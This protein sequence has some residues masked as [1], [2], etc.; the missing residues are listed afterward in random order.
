[1]DIASTVVGGLGL[2]MGG[3]G[4]WAYLSAR[5]KAPAD[6]ASA[7]AAFQAALSAQADAFIKSLQADRA[8]L[9]TDRQAL[10]AEIADLHRRVQELEAENLQC[11]GETAQMRQHIESLQEHLRRRGI[12]IP[13][14]APPRSMTVLEEGKTTVITLDAPPAPSRRSRRKAAP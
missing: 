8:A 11:R 10:H 7:Q 3:G 6:I 5:E 14:G 2:I 9:I 4:V 12:D 1:M 13:K